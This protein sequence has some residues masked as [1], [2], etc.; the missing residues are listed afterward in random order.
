MDKEFYKSW[1]FW[2]TVLLS[3]EAGF[4]VA[5][6]SYPVLEPLLMGLGSFLTLFGFRRAMK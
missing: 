2:G 3:L 5:G 1:T 6:Q 4:K